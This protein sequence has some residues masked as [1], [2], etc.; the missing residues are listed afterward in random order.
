MDT[1]CHWN[2]RGAKQGYENCDGTR[3]SA[4][5]I[6]LGRQSAKQV[7]AVDQREPMLIGWAD[8]ALLSASSQKLCD[9]FHIKCQKRLKTVLIIDDLNRR[10]SV[11]VKNLTLFVSPLR[12]KI[13]FYAQKK[14]SSVA[15]LF[16]TA[17]FCRRNAYR[18][19]TLRMRCLLRLHSF[20]F[21]AARL[22]CN[23]LPLTKATS[24]LILLPF[25]YTAKQTAE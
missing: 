1:I 3:Q 4:L 6:P 11:T 13:G 14:R 12:R 24:A 20:S 22:S 2:S 19:P 16:S 9:S 15:S 21:M 7:G 23:C 5:L 17:G 18:F 10:R 8:N 25:Q